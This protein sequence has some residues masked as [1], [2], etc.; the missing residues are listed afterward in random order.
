MKNTNDIIIVQRIFG[1]YKKGLFDR[2]NKLY[3]ITVLHSSNKSGIHQEKTTYS[4]SI[5]KIQLSKNETNVFLF[6]NKFILKQKPKVIIHE[7][8]LGIVSLPLSFIIAKILGVKFILY[9]HGYNRKKGFNPE[10]SITDKLRLLYM[11][12]SDAIIVYSEDDKNKLSKFIKNNKLFV[13]PN[14]LDTDEH[15]KIYRSLITQGRNEIKRNHK[16]HAKF[17]ITFIGR[18]TSLK[19]PEILLDILYIIKQKTTISISLNFIGDGEMLTFLQEK[20]KSLKL[21]KNVNF[22]GAIYD[23]KTT[24][25][26]LY[27]SDLLIIPE[28]L[29][30]SIN[31]AF[32][33]ECPVMSF[34]E[35]QGGPAHNPE[36]TY[37]KNNI[38]GFIIDKKDDYIEKMATIIINYFNNPELQN[39]I[40]KNTIELIYKQY[41]INI[42][43]NGFI[44]AINYVLK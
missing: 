43:V 44:Q 23:K 7:F 22:Y 21:T 20:T 12:F 40:R 32:C 35:R 10:K 2:L 14:T 17:Y 4:Q 18:L 29:G 39:T 3:R 15:Y 9:S 6:V 26:L 24:G 13:A 34:K 8:A 30:L 19:K 11:K 1:S 37:L 28:N 27:A 33:Y 16:L 25:E 42:M 31:H 36:I 41:N 5:K 38:T